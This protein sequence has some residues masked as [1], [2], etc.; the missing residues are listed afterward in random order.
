[1]LETCLWP[2]RI[3]DTPAAIPSRSSVSPMPAPAPM[4]K[5][6]QS[7]PL[8]AVGWYV[9][10]ELPGRDRPLEDVGHPAQIRNRVQLVRP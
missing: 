8:E 6:F 4:P 10:L 5:S 1:M 7:K 9:I 2:C 3:V